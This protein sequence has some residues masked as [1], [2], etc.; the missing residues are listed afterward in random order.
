MQLTKPLLTGAGVLAS[1]GMLAFATGAFAN[2]LALDHPC[3]VSASSKYG[4]TIRVTGN[5]F[6]PGEEIFAQVA[7]RLGLVTFVE[8]TVGAQGKFNATL[9]KVLPASVGPVAERVSLQIKGVL[10]EALLASTPFE[11]TNLAVTTSPAAAAATT[12]VSFSFSGFTPGA[13]VYGHYLH[14]GQVLLTHRFGT[15]EGPC[16]VLKA[17][18]W[19]YPGK[20]RYSSYTVQYDDSKA[21]ST[22]T[23]PKID[24]TVIIS[25]T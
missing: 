7:G 6:T 4:A 14:K 17:K 2:T 12:T 18:S 19:V 20:S 23:W 3:Y 22:N 11:M 13:P 25:R 8:A 9:T 21:Y 5:G 1:S 24:R 16:G 15:A 10:S